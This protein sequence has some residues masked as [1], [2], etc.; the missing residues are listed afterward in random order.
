MGRTILSGAGE[1]Y[2]DGTKPEP[3]QANRHQRRQSRSNCRSVSGCLSS[4]DFSIMSTLLVPECSRDGFGFWSLE[5][6]WMGGQVSYCLSLGEKKMTVAKGS[7]LAC[8]L[9]CTAS[10]SLNHPHLHLRPAPQVKCDRS[11]WC[12]EDC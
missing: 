4:L 2:Q 1:Q 6:D 11:A 9:K 10:T 5:S 3:Q 7:L 12:A 8:R